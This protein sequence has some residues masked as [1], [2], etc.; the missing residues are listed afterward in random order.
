MKILITG[1][2]RGIGCATALRFLS[3]GH[4]VVGIDK[5]NP[6]I[7]HA[8]YQHIVCDIWADSLPGIPDVD[9]LINNAGQQ[10]MSMEDIDVNLK[11]L[12]KCTEKYGIRQGIKAIVNIASVSG[13]NGAEFPEYAASKGGVLAYTKNVA[14]SVAEFGATCNSISPGGVLTESNNHI[15]K[16]PQ[17]WDKVMK[18]C[19]LPKWA[20]AEEIAEWIYFIA[21]VNKSMTGQD[22]VIDNGETAKFNFVW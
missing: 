3:A 1:T 8:E 13:H 14:N 12:I 5:N 18:E 15:I 2:S 7:N 19:L 10:K 22:V 17:L 11:S 20:L 4:H 21:V 9:I 6:A 16:N